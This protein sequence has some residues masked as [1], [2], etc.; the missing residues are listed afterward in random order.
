M[1]KYPAYI[2]NNGATGTDVQCHDL[3][4]ETNCEGNIVR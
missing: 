1:G 2:V 3:S 4:P